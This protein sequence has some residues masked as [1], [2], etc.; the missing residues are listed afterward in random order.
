MKVKVKE[1]VFLDYFHKY[2][3]NPKKDLKV[4]SRSALIEFLEITKCKI[5][6]GS[7]PPEGELMRKLKQVRRH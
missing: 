4:K 7:V 2:A 6:D 5:A 3:A 1:P